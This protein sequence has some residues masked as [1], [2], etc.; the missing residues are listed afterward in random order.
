MIEITNESLISL[1][2]AAEFVPRRPNGK[3]THVS[4]IYRWFGRGI[5]GERLECLRVGGR[6]CTSTEALQRFF[7]RLSHA[8][9]DGQARSG[10]ATRPASAHVE[11]ELSELGI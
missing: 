1:A 9:D 7:D 3:K 11:Q 8:H 2:Q 4:T 5:R 10:R 6:L